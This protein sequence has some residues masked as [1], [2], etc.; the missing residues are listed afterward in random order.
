MRWMEVFI[1][2]A[3][4]LGASELHLLLRLHTGGL[5]ATTTDLVPVSTTAYLL[6]GFRKRLRCGRHLLGFW[7]LFFFLFLF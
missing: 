3:Y 1:H 5:N 7:R 6:I 2:S 4:S